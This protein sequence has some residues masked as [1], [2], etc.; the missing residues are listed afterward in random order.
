MSRYI[1]A[2]DMDADDGRRWLVFDKRQAEGA[3]ESWAD[4][5]KIRKALERGEGEE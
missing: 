3:G 4:A 1:I 2:H 5:E